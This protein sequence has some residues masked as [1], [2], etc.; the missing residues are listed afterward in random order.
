MKQ[1]PIKPKVRYEGAQPFGVIPYIWAISISLMYT[2]CREQVVFCSLLMGALA[3]GAYMLVYNVQKSKVGSAIVTSLMTMAC[4]G[5]IAM[6]SWSFMDYVRMVEQTGNANDP[7][8]RSF[9]HFLFSASA[10][11]DWMYAIAAILMFAVIVGFIC[12]YFSAVLPRANYLLLPAFIPII[13]AAR[14]TGKLALPL[15]AVLFGTFV[16]AV[17]CSAR[18]CEDADVAFFGGAHEKRVRLCSALALGAVALVVALVIPRSDATP[19]GQY[20]D[21]MLQSGKGFY[22]GVSLNNFASNS[23]VNTGDNDPSDKV[24]FVAQTRV[25][26]HIDRWSFD[27]YNGAE[28]WTYIPSE[29]NTGYADWPLYAKERSYAEL[30]K[31]LIK[32]AESGKLSGYADMLSGLEK[33]GA[34][35]CELYIRIVDT[36]GFSA[37]IMHPVSA[38]SAEIV[39]I[40]VA[41]I[42]RTLKGE[43]F[44]NADMAMAKYLVGFYADEPNARYSEIV[45]QAGFEALLNESYFDGV[46]DFAAYDAFLDEYKN[47]M[48]YYDLAGLGG[49][50]PEMYDLA[51]EITEGCKSDYEKYCAIEQWFGENGFVY[52][53]DF[54]PQSTETEYFVFDSKRGICSDF[55]TATTLLAR[56]AGLPARY[57]EGFALTEDCRDEL[58]VY[59][60]TAAQAHAYTQVYVKGCGWLNLD[61][62]KFVETADGSAKWQSAVITLI[63]AAVVIVLLVLGLVFRKQLCV[64]IFMMTYRMRGND[65][66]IKAVYL[67]TRAIACELSDSA[68]EITT[69]GETQTVIANMLSMPDEA[70]VICDA[71]DKLMYSAGNVDADTDELY[72]CFRRICRRKRVLKR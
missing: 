50:S 31:T 7:N 58:G 18:K 44:A 25:P 9:A 48:R 54:V 35:T 49:I 46:I 36:T 2:I 19:M 42:Y 56:A 66:R 4:F 43:M 38:Y 61:A 22:S 52:D 39:D 10:Y 20:M 40:E 33:Y 13:L 16:S 34:T 37:V 65:S 47:A 12:C 11:F 24:L 17:L 26:Y 3:T 62:T 5:A 63:V 71:A 32:G 14:T 8:M 21:T 72:R 45:E 69:C 30:F 23:S 70:K 1:R 27:V 64:L 55:A 57:T 15:M 53:L 51:H 41:T 68:E 60:V 67:H 6:V 28:G 59:N 29:Y